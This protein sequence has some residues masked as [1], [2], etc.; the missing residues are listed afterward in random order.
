MVLRE[1]FGQQ[2][3]G[4]PWNMVDKIMLP[5]GWTVIYQVILELF[6]S[7]QYQVITFIHQILH[8]KGFRQVFLMRNLCFSVHKICFLAR[9]HA[10]CLKSVEKPPACS[11]TTLSSQRWWQWNYSGESDKGAVDRNNLDTSWLG[12]FHHWPERSHF[13]LCPEQQTDTYEQPPVTAL[14]RLPT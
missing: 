6:M 3:D 9:L 5:S 2:L 12:R 8:S 7:C 4:L 14:V 11:K 1:K 10:S 13:P